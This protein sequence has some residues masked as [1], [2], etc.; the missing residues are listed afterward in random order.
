[1][2]RDI[3]H[4]VEIHAERAI[5]FDAIATQRGQPVF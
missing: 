2:S 1:M 3:L 4:A 5:L